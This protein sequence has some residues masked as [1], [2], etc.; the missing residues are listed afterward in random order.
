[1]EDCKEDKSNCT[2][3]GFLIDVIEELVKMFNFTY[4][5]VKYLKKYK[6]KSKY[7]HSKRIINIY[8]PNEDP[9]MM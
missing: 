6:L 7:R 2:S 5:S 4:K 3:T 1:M 8:F 9:T